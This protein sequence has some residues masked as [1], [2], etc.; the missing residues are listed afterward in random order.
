MPFHSTRHAAGATRPR[1]RSSARLATLTVSAAAL[2]GACSHDLDASLPYDVPATYEANRSTTAPKVSAWWTR[3][4]S[5]ELDG[6]MAAAGDDNLDIAVAAAQLEQAEAQSQITRALLFPT[7]GFS[8]NAS[9]AQSSGTNVAKVVSTPR[10]GDQFSK[11]L[12]ASYVIDV[13][14]ANRDQ[15]R[16]SLHNRDASAYQVQ[17]VRLTALSTVA[18]NY[19][20]YAADLERIMV[21]EENLANARRILQVIRERVNAQTASDLDLSQQQALVETQKVN[22]ATLR[23]GAELSRTALALALGRPPQGFHPSIKSLRRLRLPQVAGGLPS[24]LLVRRPDVRAAEEQ[25]LADDANVDV[26]RKAFLPTITLTGSAG[27]QSAELVNLI[28]PQSIVWSIAQGLTQPIFEGGKLR[29][30]LRLSEAQRQQLLETYRKSILSALTDVENALIS[31]REDA[32]REQAQRLA[33]NA[34]KQAF[35]LSEQRL[36][37]GTID[38]TTLLTVQNALFAAQDSLIQIRLARLQAVVSLFQAIGGD[39]DDQ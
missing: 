26:A 6:Y 34:S 28:R 12:N 31:I 13:W 1:R 25:M 22:I 5:G 17:V 27:Y 8:E 11:I 7:L 35:D 3:F 4:G 36:G 21:A 33:V 32:R 9:R 29:G 20:L 2:L 24:S 10:I 30:Q 14:G 19:L 15:L 39:W 37:A 38:L 16:A 23:L 18:N